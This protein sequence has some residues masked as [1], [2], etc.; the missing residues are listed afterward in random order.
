MLFGGF[1]PAELEIRKRRNGSRRLRGR[2]PYR[3]K[4]V[5][6]DG[7][8][9]GGK[10]KK[11]QF[12]PGAFTYRLSLPPQDGDI[13]LLF[14]H[15]YDKPLASRGTQTLTFGDTAEAL[16]FEAEIT[17]EIADT[18]H[19][20]DT[21]ALIESGLSV[22]ISPGFRIP[23]PRAVP[24]DQ[25]EKI[26]QEVYDPSRKMFGALIRSIFAAL[27]YELSIV[28]APAYKD[29]TVESGDDAPVDENGDGIDD[30]TGEQIAARNW[31]LDEPSGLIV[32]RPHTLARW[33]L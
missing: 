1:D 18:T 9:N 10:P 30:N 4:A 6:S 32:P 27:L 19:G 16:T 24:A 33:R 2:F 29:A 12:M 21:L 3:K 31:K 20:R 13:H 11:E 26:E 15:D 23:P 8:R 28:T 7:G 17:P 14:G 5:L 22:G 25:A